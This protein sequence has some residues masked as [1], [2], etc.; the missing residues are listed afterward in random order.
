MARQLL[1]RY[2]PA[3]TAFAVLV[4]LAACGLS[5]SNSSGSGST[6]GTGSIGGFAAGI[7]GAGQTSSA[8]FLVALQVPGLTPV[9]TSINSSGTLT[10]ATVTTEHYS[11]NNPMAIT[12]AIDPSG[13]YFYEA[14]QPGLW[15]FTIDR[16]NGNLTET[17]VSPYDDTVEFQ[18]QSLSINSANL[19]MPTPERAMFMPTPFSQEPV[20]PP[21]AGRPSQPRHR[22]TSFPSRPI[23][24]PSR[25]MTNI[26]MLQPA[27]GMVAYSI[28][29]PPPEH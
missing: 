26:S 1:S 12:G 7:G 11:V 14:V 8:Q 19:S 24:L 16:Q 5:T 9:A 2:S 25:R 13:T 27:P 22:T 29:A 18:T 17:S 28:D 20:T 4:F 3:L 23:A 15:A 6:G 21:I 10:A